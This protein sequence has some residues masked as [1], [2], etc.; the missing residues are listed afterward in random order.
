MTLG[1]RIQELR[2]TMGLSQEVLGEKLG[3]SRQAI[4]KWE[5]DGAV[6]E[7]DKLIALGRL[8]EVSLNEL[9][10]V[11]CPADTPEEEERSAEEYTRKAH[12]RRALKDVGHALTAMLVAVLVGAVAI[13]WFRMGRLSREL[14]ELKTR[15]SSDFST[16]SS[17][18]G[19]LEV[20]PPAT[21]EIDD[22][23]SDQ[24]CEVASVDIDAGTTTLRLSVTP[25]RYVE[26]MSAQ[27][28]ITGQN[29]ATITTSP[30]NAEGQTFAALVTLPL[31]DKITVTAAIQDGDATET[32]PLGNFLDLKKESGIILEVVWDESA[33]NKVA[34]STTVGIYSTAVPAESSLRV[35]KDGKIL[36]EESII[37]R[38]EN[39]AESFGGNGQAEFLGTVTFYIPVEN[40]PEGEI[41]A[42]LKDTEGREY[43]VPLREN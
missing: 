20:W 38:G 19:S 24:I 4:S 7:V 9:L 41:E 40:W 29:F 1:Q 10:Q 33:A 13:L 43:I 31:D 32:R 22:F 18:I 23:F 34:V 42:Y 21:S 15:V 5:A 26:G 30:Q 12:L 6:P 37:L 16:L 36:R 27:F 11:D 8:F 28:T 3:I 2:K 35:K 17:R 39:W 25:K 14:D